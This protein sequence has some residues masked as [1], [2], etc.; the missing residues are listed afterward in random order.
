MRIY[1]GHGNEV[2]SRLNVL[3]STGSLEH[4]ESFSLCKHLLHPF[5]T[6]IGLTYGSSVKINSSNVAD[7]VHI[8]S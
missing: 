2:G 5:G 7:E 8:T 3:F 1:K 4:G 6:T